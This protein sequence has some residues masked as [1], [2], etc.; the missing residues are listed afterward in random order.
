[1]SPLRGVSD[2]PSA[3]AREALVDFEPPCPGAID[4]WPQ[5]AHFPF[6]AVALGGAKAPQCIE[7]L[8]V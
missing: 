8:L 4:D 7:E 6:V 5:P 1:M 3:S 2:C